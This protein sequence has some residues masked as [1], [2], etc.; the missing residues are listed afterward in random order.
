[1]RKN[2]LLKFLL[3]YGLAVFSCTEKGSPGATSTVR[4]IAMS[5]PVVRIPVRVWN[6][7]TSRSALLQ[8]PES[9]AMTVG[10]EDE[11]PQGPQSFEVLHDGGF[12]IT[13]PLQQRL[14]FY[15]SLGKYLDSWWMGFPAN[16]VALMESGELEVGHAVTEAIYLVDDTRQ[17]RLVNPAGRGRRDAA[18]PGEA[19]MQRGTNHGHITGPIT[20][21]GAAGTLEINFESDSTQM[22]S[23]ESLGTDARGFTYVALE[24]AAADTVVK[25]KKIIRKYAA[26]GA[27]VGQI[28]DIAIDYEVAPADEF[29]VRQ[30][31]V[32]QLV[33]KQ[34]EI[35]IRVWN[36]N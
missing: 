11:L 23:L 36:T 16:S 19:E 14:V 31:L 1:M 13:D 12:V 35:Q 24:T 9:L 22:V 29:R 30:G 20:R 28:L 33:P 15:D 26:D 27:L 7:D 6:G 25:V 10:G 34:N 21:G 2:V 3:A 4:V 18:M 17:P 5:L 8:K 32:Y